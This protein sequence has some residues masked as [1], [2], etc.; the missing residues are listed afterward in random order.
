LH[1]ISF[2]QFSLSP[3]TLGIKNTNIDNTN[4]DINIVTK[5][6][7]IKKGAVGIRAQSKIGLM[8]NEDLTNGDPNKGTKRMWIV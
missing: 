8:S 1:W 5:S 4:I 7:N 3:K 2:H 6:L